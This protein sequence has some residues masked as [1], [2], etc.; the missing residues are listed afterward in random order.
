MKKTKIVT[1]AMLGQ[2]RA[3]R[4]PITRRYT[5][6]LDN[7][8]L[9]RVVKVLFDGQTEPRCILENYLSFAKRKSTR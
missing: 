9:S 4:W 1:H 6:V 5:R 3:I 8:R 7:G 2:G